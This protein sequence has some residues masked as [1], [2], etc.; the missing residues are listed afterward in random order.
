VLGTAQSDGIHGTSSWLPPR[1][2]FNRPG[3]VEQ[4]R[5]QLVSV[6]YPMRA[7]DA[8]TLGGRPASAY[9]LMPLEAPMPDLPHRQPVPHH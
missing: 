8:V 5:V 9:L 1:V 2:M 6:P 7:V 4:S 3:E